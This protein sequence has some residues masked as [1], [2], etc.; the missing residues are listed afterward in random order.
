MKRN[1]LLAA[2]LMFVCTFSY[3]QNNGRQRMTVEERAKRTTEWMQKELKLSDDQVKKVEPIN[4]SFAK[5]TQELRE[6]T[7]RD[8]RKGMREAMEK[9][10]K[11]RDEAL[12]K[13][14]TEEQMKL[15]KEKMKERESQRR[16]NNSR[17][18]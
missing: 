13:V 11:E 14:L 8:D 9:L 2:V 17:R 5:A 16:N 18:Q 10:G 1:L 6:K 7:S 12:A 15:Y 3:A 4:L